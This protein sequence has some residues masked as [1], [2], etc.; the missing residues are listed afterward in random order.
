[1]NWKQISMSAVRIKY[2]D[3]RSLMYV[4]VVQRSVNFSEKYT[5]LFKNQCIRNRMFT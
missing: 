5:Y 2:L 4:N 1:M 3:V